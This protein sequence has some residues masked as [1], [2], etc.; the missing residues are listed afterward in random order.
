[1]NEYIF[2]NICTD[3]IAPDVRMLLMYTVGKSV[4]LNCCRLHTLKDSQ[5]ACEWNNP[6]TTAFKLKPARLGT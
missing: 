3:V 1:M 5:L 4:K 6:N 2:Y